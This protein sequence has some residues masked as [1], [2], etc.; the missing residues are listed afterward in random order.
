MP[1]PQHQDMATS[2]RMLSVDAVAAAKS[3]HSGMP[4]GFADVA[5]VLFTDFLKF[6]AADPSWADRDRFILSAGHGSMLL[7]SLLH[8]TGYRDVRLD[9]IKNFR[10]LG[11]NTPGHPEFGLTSGVE[12]TTG[13]LGQGLAN[14]VGFALAEARLA[15]EFGADLV[16]HHT[17]V[18]VGDGCLMEGVSQEAITLAGH[19]NLSKLVLLWDHNRVTIDGA[20]DLATSEDQ[21]KR[22]H[23]AG[24]ETFECDG[25][26]PEDI[27]QAIA[28]AKASPRPALVAC[29][30]TIAFGSAKFAGT[31]KGHGAITDAEDVAAIREQL[32]WRH[33]AFVV[34]G[35][36]KAAW[37][38]VGAKGAEDQ[39]AWETRLR[40]H[41]DRDAF[42]DRL[43][44][45]W[46]DS[47]DAAIKTHIEAMAAAQPKIA[48]RVASGKA[49]ETLIPVVPAL[50]GGSADL[51][52]SNNTKIASHRNFSAAMHGG[53]YLNY[54]VREHAMA[55][56]M[57]GL[58]LHGGFIPYAGTFLVFSDYARPAIRLAALMGLKVIYVFTH[59]SIG[60]GEDGPTH[61]PVEHISAL[62]AIP[63]LLVMR[64]AD[65]VETMECWKLALTDGRPC[66][67]ALSRQSVP[68]I[69]HDH[70]VEWASY[71]G[72]IHSPSNVD[73]DRQVTLMSSGT[74]LHLAK[75][76]QESLEA[77]GIATAVI[78][79]P[80]MEVFAEQPAHYRSEVL[81]DGTLRVAVEAGVAQGW[82]RW[83][84]HDDGFVGMSTFG[85]SAP[86]DDLYAHFGISA[87]AIV[88]AVKARL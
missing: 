2:I 13:P 43:A 40:G 84:S 7:Y 9:Q 63:G 20:T 36:I 46:P 55:A 34:P 8:L 10:Q 83:M 72:Y 74:E 35:E 22:F 11:S 65:A 71:G 88:E 60:V 12:T 56:C 29:R 49:L 51:S 78:S 59:D 39:S 76:A 66:V 61:Q 4:M 73:G 86:A 68:H 81:G 19:L 52:G 53:D 31:A 45:H 48:T 14:A 54:G 67:L 37:E 21:A 58:A 87:T 23:A 77:D 85:A 25:H 16:D 28:A 18:A 82:Y 1:H 17:F 44:G 24:W 57:N 47:A 69:R 62:R 32:H 6:N 5:T 79:M 33:P 42:A 30:T 64:P 50:I 26:D 80:C 3:G 15:A 41:K 70:T 27:A 75:Q 38:G